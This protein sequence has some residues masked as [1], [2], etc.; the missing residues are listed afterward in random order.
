MK[1]IFKKFNK[2]SNTYTGDSSDLNS[3]SS[4]LTLYSINSL[5]NSE[6]NLQKVSS[7]QRFKNMLSKI[8]TINDNKTSECQTVSSDSLLLNINQYEY[9][10][11][12]Y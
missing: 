5:P 3:I 2:P 8:M 1:S 6:N 4:S 7:R 9:L 12:I 10:G 11:Y